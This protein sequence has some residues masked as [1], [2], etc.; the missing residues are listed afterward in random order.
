[1]FFYLFFSALIH[2]FLVGF[3]ISHHSSELK[4]FNPIEMI[5]TSTSEPKLQ[6]L[7]KTPFAKNQ[8]QETESKKSN[9]MPPPL[10]PEG[11]RQKGWEGEVE[12]VLQTN[13]E[14]FVKEAKLIKS[15]GFLILDQTALET[16][17]K[18]RLSPLAE[19]H[20]P[21]HFQLKDE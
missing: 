17:K 21:F 18:W 2:V 8:T 11:A 9:Y 4:H 10:Y 1:M 16:A 5:I 19:L 13:G 6:K 3:L 12:I 15:S 7:K 14:G 20:V